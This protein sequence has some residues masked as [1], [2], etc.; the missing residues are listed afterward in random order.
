MSTTPVDPA[1]GAWPVCDLTDAQIE[2]EILEIQERLADLVAER[3]DRAERD[4]EI[5]EAL[6]SRSGTRGV[7]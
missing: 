6:Q 7:R 5:D 3:R 2:R 4:E 1:I